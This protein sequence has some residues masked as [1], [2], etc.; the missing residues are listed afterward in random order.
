LKGAVS[1]LADRS[2]DLEQA[3]DAASAKTIL[4]LGS[5]AGSLVGFRGPL[6]QALVQRGHRV[7][8]CAPA[9]PAHVL[10][11]LA[12]MGVAYR[13]IPFDRTGLRPGRDLHTLRALVH[14]FREVRP[15]IVLG[16]TIKPVIFGSLVAQ[17]T[18]VPACFSMITG[19][20]HTLTATSWR[21][22]ALT[23]LVRFLYRLAL[24]SNRKL[25][26]QN[27]DDRALFERLNLV[28]APEQAILVN[29]SGIDLEAFRPAPLPAD[30]SF[31]LLARLIAAKGIREYVGAAR[32]VRAKYP[33]VIFRLAGRID[34][35]P[36]AISPWEL[37]AWI[38]EGAIEYLG[39]LDD[40]RPAIAACSVY[41]LPSYYGEGIPRSV[42]EAMAM[43]RAI[44]TTDA[45]GCRETVQEGINGYLVPVRDALALAQ[46]LETLVAEPNLVAAMGGESRRIAVE[47]YD[48]HKVNSVILRA[49]GLA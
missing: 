6:L 34:D 8:G 15:D 4:V 29:G 30:T 10:E 16:Y 48:V 18:G 33:E 44:V 49:M 37:Q 38:K 41:V 21:T 13:D 39:R 2:V 43:G 12:A 14:L 9:A 31:L 19:L 46:A 1:L 32:T 28:R 17:W 47:T 7:V 20:G 40:V 27:P 11:A 45:P 36:T 23:P 5:I 25:F 42:L 26:F 3:P 24:K 35:H 22:R